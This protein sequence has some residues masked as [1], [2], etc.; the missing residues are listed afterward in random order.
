M[1]SI[2]VYSI[3]FLLIILFFPVFDQLYRFRWEVIDYTHAYFVLPVSLICAWRE[4]HVFKS[5][6]MKKPG[7]FQV[8]LLFFIV[9]LALFVFAGREGYLFLSTASLIP[10]LFSLISYLY[11]WPA[12]ISFSFPI[13]YLLLLVPP[14]MG[15]LDSV[16]IPMRYGVSMAVERTLSIFHYPVTRSG[17]LLSIRDHQIFMDAPCS[18]FRSLI[19]MVS[20]ALVYAYFNKGKILKKILL[21]MSVIPLA[22]AGNFIRVTGTCLATYY[23]GEDIARAFHDYSGYAVFLLLMGGLIGFDNLLGKT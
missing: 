21:V 14:P 6:V 1:G 19:T 15:I 16:T 20:L 4:R 3:W 10:I 18:G 11:G 5:R 12:G 9:S 2:P 17:L 7:V 22:L 8:W 13:L 23:A